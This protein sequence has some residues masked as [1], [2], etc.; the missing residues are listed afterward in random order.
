MHVDWRW[1]KQ[2]PQFLAENL[3]QYYDV[4]VG[5][6][7]KND[8]RGLRKKEKSF[9]SIFPYFN[10][11]SFNG[12]LKTIN[13]INSYLSKFQ[14]ITLMYTFKPD[15]IWVAYPLQYSYLPKK[16]HCK[17]I[18]DCMDDY[19]AINDHNGE[20]DVIF[21][22]EK[23]LL[24]KAQ[25]IF[26]SSNNLIC[27]LHERYNVS[28]DN[29]TLLRNGY[30]D[31]WK[32]SK[33]D[34]RKDDHI[35][36]IGYFGTI[37]RWFDFGVL[38]YYVGRNPN[39]E[40]HLYGPC[41]KGIKIIENPHI[42]YHG[43]AEHDLLPELMKDIKVLIMPFKNNDIVQSVDPVKLYE[44]ISLK[45]DIVCLFYKEIS[46]FEPFVYFYQGDKGFEE[47]MEKCRYSVTRK[48]SDEKANQFLINNTW[49]ARADKVYNMLEG[50]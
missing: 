28:L 32:I 17:L 20:N 27:L 40:I 41:E 33:S 29:I 42:F 50:N 39:T 13:K 47:Q 22:S 8:R 18:Y 26:A 12:K 6:P 19:I 9:V 37:G 7:F 34:L 5:Y 45:K 14:I 48:Y 46:H 30:S 2:R 21:A 4:I 11:V 44:Y 31:N 38:E 36:R 24:E 23:A 49:K 10:F 15:Y 16:L 43:T 25:F 35:L 3:E 1:I